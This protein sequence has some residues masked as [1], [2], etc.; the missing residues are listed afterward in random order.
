MFGKEIR[1]KYFT[2][3][4]PKVNPINHGSYGLTP[5][6]VFDTFVDSMKEDLQHPD[7]YMSET[8]P[9]EYLE[10]LMTIG[11]VINSDYRN[12]ALI[13]NATTGINVIY[14]SMKWEK[15]D[16]VLVTSVVYDS[17]EH[18]LEYMAQMFGIELIKLN[19]DIEVPEQE[20]V[21]SFENV[22]KT[23]D[24]KLVMFDLVSSMPAFLFPYKQLLELTKKYNVISVID[25]A[26][27]VGMFPI[28]FLTFK[29]DFFTSNLHKWY[30]VPRPC[31]I[32][33]VDPKFHGSIQPFPISHVFI[34]YEGENTL[35][36]KFYFLASKNY[37]YYN[38]VKSA[39]GFREMIG[40]DEKIW[41]YCQDLKHKV[42]NYLIERW[43][44]KAL[45]QHQPLQ[46]VNIVLPEKLAITRTADETPGF[47]HKVP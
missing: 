11:E 17:C 1:E 43:D 26:H 35:I 23:Q 25:G 45:S 28:D 15:G 21:D 33:Y 29:P 13:D 34:D 3:L 20:L 22:F 46:M 31:A 27:G 24:I 42:T 10:G 47:V 32:L 30:Y 38:C 5:T 12:L 4:N 44:T 40:G 18:V 6:P 16:K 19:V 37:A 14:R 41:E 2:L 39:K 36:K 8:E 9:K 7:K